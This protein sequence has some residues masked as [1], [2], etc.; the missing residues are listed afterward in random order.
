MSFHDVA[1][2]YV[3]QL[4]AV[5]G[6]DSN[7]SILVLTFLDVFRA[8]VVVW[9]V[10]DQVLEFLLVE[11]VDRF[12]E[13]EVHG[14]FDRNAH[15]ID[16]YVGIRGDDRP[17]R[18]VD[19]FAHQVASYPALF[20]LETLRDRAQGSTGALFRGRDA[21][22]LIVDEGRYVVLNE[23][24]PRAD[25]FFGRSP[26]LDFLFQSVVSLDDVAQLVSEVVL[27]T[28]PG[29]VPHG[30]SDG[31]RRHGEYRAYE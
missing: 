22:K 28:L 30:R 14:D 5:P 9:A 12:R 19:S 26:G 31:R 18:E 2:F 3:F 20:G 4:I 13:R 21:G 1:V 27:A 15:L 7:G 23:L 25:G 11:P 10:F 17:R 24:C 16:G 29:V 8:G 6:V